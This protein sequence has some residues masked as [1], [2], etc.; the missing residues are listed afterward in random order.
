MGKIVAQLFTSLDG[1]VEAP[2]KWHFPFLNDEMAGEV[3]AFY[4]RAD[5]LLLGR[6]TYDVFAGSW[7]RR[8]H[9][10]P[11][12]HR[13][14]SMPKVVVTSGT[15][16]LEWANSSAIRSGLRAELT[17]MALE[18]E[19]TLAV[20]GSISLIRWLLGEHLLDELQ[21]MIHPIV[22]GRGQM[23]FAS[24]AVTGPIEFEL[25]QSTVYTT[26]VIDV[27]YSALTTATP[28]TSTTSRS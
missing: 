7:P 19:N 23:L 17:R 26:G 18:T 27:T 21:L 1:V 6:A 15:E 12:A 9:N 22:L 14:N 10:D 20:V 28:T 4:D 3:S 25:T 24:G 2:E 5:V 8:P 16:S 13:I 11:L